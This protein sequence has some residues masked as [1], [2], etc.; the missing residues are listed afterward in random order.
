MRAA[1]L[2]CGRYWLLEALTS[3][4]GPIVYRALEREPEFERVVAI[5]LP[6]LASDVA[7]D[8]AT[9]MR[10]RVQQLRR[11]THANLVTLLEFAKCSEGYYLAMEWI[12]GIDLERLLS[13]LSA[14]GL[15]A[16]I[17]LM[18]YIVAEAA[19][20]LAFAHGQASGSVL[21]RSI[22]PSSILVD[23]QGGV[24]LGGFALLEM[25]D[26]ATGAASER[27]RYLSPEQVAAEPL[28]ARADV[29]SL[30]LVLYEALTGRPCAD[31]VSREELL[32]QIRQ[33]RFALPSTRRA[34]LPAALD[35]I[36][37][38]TLATDREQ[39]F[40]DAGELHLALRRYLARA[41]PDLSRAGVAT[42]LSRL[43]S[44]PREWALTDE[45]ESGD[46][47]L[48]SAG[49]SGEASLRP[50]LTTLTRPSGSNRRWF[51]AVAVAVLAAGLAFA[52]LTWNQPAAQVPTRSSVALAR[53][54]SIPAVRAR[55]G[56]AASDPSGLIT[57]E[58][59]IRYE[60]VALLRNAAGK[61]TLRLRITNL[62][63]ATQRLTLA[64]ASVRGSHL[65]A[66]PEEMILP[67]GRW[68]EAL[69]ETSSDDAVAADDVLLLADGHRIALPPPT[70]TESPL[71]R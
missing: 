33:T 52:W 11:L 9:T 34:G 59:N 18:V 55:A 37:A 17:H 63:A 35:E 46:A 64:R 2:R 13:S 23:L 43:P 27:L 54:A 60:V 56:A 36:V 10:K 7:V 49:R 68:R 47:V 65:R 51:A 40:A 29:F 31:A 41:A 5:K 32:R 4:D 24:H 67:P 8:V 44:L 53:E 66:T 3:G 16:D 45:N 25:R 57:S 6:V 26:P 71:Q 19:R 21:H 58:R 15:A 69:L 48:S 12:P 42:L 39:R 14:A 70:A 30:G 50:R 20:G 28:D 38:R 1:Q 62:S 61:R 22:R